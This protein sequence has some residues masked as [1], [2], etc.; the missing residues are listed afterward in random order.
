MRLIFF[1]ICPIILH[2][3]GCSY[4]TLKT[5]LLK[6]LEHYLYLFFTWVHLSIY[7][8]CWAF[9]ASNS[10]WKA[11]LFDGLVTLYLVEDRGAILLL[12][13]TVGLSV[14]V[15]FGKG[16]AFLVSLCVKLSSRRSSASSNKHFSVTRASD[17]WAAHA[18]KMCSLPH[19]EQLG[20]FNLQINSLYQRRCTG[21][22]ETK[23][24][25]V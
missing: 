16:R 24:S 4:Y 1:I 2:V 7:L 25:C 3:Y 19:W 22:G 8:C 21:H 14:L 12:L 11:P 5:R 10:W 20:G 9:V 23:L 18:H 15:D 13:I 17:H 6:S